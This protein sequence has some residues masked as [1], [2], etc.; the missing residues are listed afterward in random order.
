MTHFSNDCE[1]I[2]PEE[3]KHEELEVSL[4]RRIPRWS[5]K[6]NG[7]LPLK[8]FTCNKIGDIATRCLDK[9]MKEKSK[10]N[11]IITRKHAT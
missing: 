8:C 10:Y 2:I 9:D 7:K 3:N 1:S 6:Y 11:S 4:A 5:D